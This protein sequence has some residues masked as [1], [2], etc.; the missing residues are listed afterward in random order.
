[1]NT[2]NSLLDEHS[3]INGEVSDLFNNFGAWISDIGGGSQ[4]SLCCGED[5]ESHYI[6][7]DTCIINYIYEDSY[8][9]FTTRTKLRVPISWLGHFYLA[10]TLT[11]FYLKEE[12]LKV[13]A[14]EIETEHQHHVES[15]R[16]QAQELGLL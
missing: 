15:I 12:I 7:G 4:Y 13:V 11:L 8:N 9:D 16:R 3:R 6:A 2:V 5:Y 1:M 10:D 14:T